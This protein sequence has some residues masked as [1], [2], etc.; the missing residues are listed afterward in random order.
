MDIIETENKHTSGLY[1]K[2]P[3]II[4]RGEAASLWDAD[5]VEYIDCAAGHGV[6]NLGHA[7][8]KVAAAIAQQST[9]LRRI[10]R[11]SAPDVRHDLHQN[12]AH[13]FVH[14]QHPVIMARDC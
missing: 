12:I 11:D 3:I 4:V 6:A 7:H 2:Q 9:Q 8:P 10:L 5:G 14:R 1:T 13:A